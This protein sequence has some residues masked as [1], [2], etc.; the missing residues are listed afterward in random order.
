[1]SDSSRFRGFSIE[2]D[3]KAEF[4]RQFARQDALFKDF[5]KVWPDVRAEFYQIENEQFDSEGGK[6]G[7][8]RWKELSA[9]YKVRKIARYGAGKKIMEAT[10]DLRRSLTSNGEGSVYRTTKDTIEIGSSI[11]Y[12]RYHQRGS[13]K[14][15]KRKIID[16]SEEQKKR[17]TKTVQRSLIRELRLGGNYLPVTER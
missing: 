14:L 4:S 7:S 17:L 16:F 3:G 1:M 5:T 13:G 15:P 8:G 9:R 2:V 6:G 11:D 10:G 12:G